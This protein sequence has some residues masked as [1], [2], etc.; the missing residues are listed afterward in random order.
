MTRI[1]NLGVAQLGPIARD[2]SRSSA[3]RRMIELMEQAH[4]KKVELI[5]FPELALTTFFP[6]WYLEDPAELEAFFETEMP[7]QATQ[8][9]FDAA[10]RMGIGFYLGYA[11]LLYT[12]P[13]PRDA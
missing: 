12:S 2:E 10:A 11:C 5:V 3:V 8:P 4:Q 1:L 6:R 7:N 9:L 13:S